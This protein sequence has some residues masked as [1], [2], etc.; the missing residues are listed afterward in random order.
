MRSLIT[1]SY[2]RLAAGGALAVQVAGG[3]LPADTPFRIEVTGED[4]VLALVGGAP[5]GFQAGL[6]NLSL[7]GEPVKVDESETAALPDPVVNVARVY[8]ALR[9]DIRNGTSTAP[10]FG[11]AARL[12]HLIDD[13]H[14]A[15][16]TGQTTAPTADWP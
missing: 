7:N 9:D 15:A 4:G 5:R 12:S 13:I 8:A 10:D 11:H 1:C 6:L 2:G 14:A 3:R 16:A